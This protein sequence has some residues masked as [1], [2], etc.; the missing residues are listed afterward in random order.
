[1]ANIRE[2][3]S[4]LTEVLELLA[5]KASVGGDYNKG[6]EDGK[7]QAYDAFWDAYQQNGTR[8]QYT[9]AFSGHGWNDVSYNPK[10]DIV[11]TDQCDAMFYNAQKITST[12]KPII[13]DTASAAYNMFAYCM[14]LKSIPSIKVTEQVPYFTYWFTYCSALE[15][16][17]FTEDSIISSNISFGDCYRLNTAS[18]N[19]IIA[20][21]KDYSQAPGNSAIT[22][23]VNVGA[24]LTEEQKAIFEKALS[25]LL[26]V[27]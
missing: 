1:M 20:A 16:L 10:Y 12:K 9:Y 17:I 18:V 23:H 4:E 22:F 27:N 5:S 6:V 21:L 15:E 25:E 24:K 2:N 3:T 11:A 8:T 13:I 14:A 19:S 26:G 7:Q